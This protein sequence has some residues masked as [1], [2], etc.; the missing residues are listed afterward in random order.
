M[1]R[2]NWEL[3]MKNA[4]KVPPLKDEAKEFKDLDKDA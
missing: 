2:N 3:S 1:A 4:I